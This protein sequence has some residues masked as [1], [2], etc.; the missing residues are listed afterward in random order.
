MHPTKV[1]EEALHESIESVEIVKF[2]TCRGKVLRWAVISTTNGFAVVG[3][4]SCAVDPANDNEDQGKRIAFDN[5]EA[6]LWELL[7]YELATK[8][9]RCALP[10]DERV[11]KE[12]A[13][14]GYNI[15]KLQAFIDSPEFDTRIPS[16]EERT[17]MRR[18]LAAMQTHS[19]ILTARLPL[20]VSKKAN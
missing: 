12:N 5:S 4:P 6:K 10:V 16:V 14:L 17:L 11:S 19:E 15:D 20:L 9:H 2:T 7:G 3:A 18:Q 1:T 13:E 8:R